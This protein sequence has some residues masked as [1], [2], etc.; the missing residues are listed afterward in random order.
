ML[1]TLRPFLCRVHCNA[2]PSLPLIRT[3]L[4]F[5]HLQAPFLFCLLITH[6]TLM[7]WWRRSFFSPLSHVFLRT[8]AAQLC[9]QDAQEDRRIT[10][11]WNIAT[12]KLSHV[13]SSSATALH[14]ERSEPVTEKFCRKKKK[15]KR[16][17]HGGIQSPREVSKLYCTCR[18]M[19]LIKADNGQQLASQ[20]SVGPQR[21]TR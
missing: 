16:G 6:N 5:H 1:S 21:M 17:M 13:Q 14:Q 20:P 7:D 10:L 11:R 18:Q 19:Q 12:S 3:S 2:L 15:E 4:V 9:T 8:F